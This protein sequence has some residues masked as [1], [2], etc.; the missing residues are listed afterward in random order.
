MR[1]LLDK[2]LSD[3]DLEPSEQDFFIGTNQSSNELEITIKFS[4]ITEDAAIA[5]LKGHVD[6]NGDCYFRYSASKADLKFQ[7][8]IGYS[9]ENMEEINGRFYLKY[10]NLKYVHSQRDLL[11]FVQRE[12]KQ[13]LSIAQQNLSAEHTLEDSELLE[14]I[15]TDLELLNEKISQLYYVSNATQDV[16]CELQKLGHHHENY[17]VQLDSGAIRVNEFIE[18]LQLSGNSNG[19]KVMLGG[20]GRNN[21]ILLALWKAKTVRE[22]QINDG[23]VFYVIE[24]PEAHLHPHQQR[25]L[26]RYLID[27]LPG[28]SIISSHSPQIAA[29]YAPDSIIRLYIHRDRTLAASDGCSDCISIAWENLGYRMSIL[30]AEAFFAN[31]VFLV[32]GPSEMLLY[33]ALAQQ[34]SLDLD[35]LNASLLSVD[36][37]AFE[38]YVKILNALQIPWVVRTDNDVSKIKNKEKW[39]YSGTNRALKLA[40]QKKWNH[41]QS[42]A[43]PKELL[44][45][46]QWQLASDAVNPDGIFLAK[47]DLESDLF[48]EFSEHMRDCFGTDTDK[49]TVEYLQKKKAIRMRKLLKAKREYLHELF[50]GEI[51]KPL[52]KLVELAKG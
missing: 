4:C 2:S 18:K 28:Q 30:P 20:D 22:H 5:I 37:V 7:L 6:D 3:A 26:A 46:G 27:E 8:F 44:E 19:S 17:E 16:N 52:N 38:V 42:K 51:V 1:L 40:N 50:S 13:L 21:Q 11:K 10:I 36:G 39:Q 23:V 14:E 43:T 32:E 48:S 35:Y 33:M 31:A 45:S 47:I 34:L 25:K 24:E 9:I 29:N 12:K 15:G 49:A 41:M